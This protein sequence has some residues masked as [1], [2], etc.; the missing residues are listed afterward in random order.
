MQMWIDQSVTS[1]SLLANLRE[2]AHREVAWEQFV[3]RYGGRIYEWCLLKR[4]QPADAEDVTQNVL[5][6]LVRRLCDFEYHSQ[7]SF[8]GWLRRVTE[9]AIIDF[10]REQR[11]RNADRLNPRLCELLELSEDRE[12]LASRLERA[13]DIELF[14]LARERVRARVDSRRWMAWE[15]TSIDQR[16]SQEVALELDMKVPTVYSSRYQVQ[17]LIT[18]EI[19]VLESE[20][21]HFK[22]QT[23]A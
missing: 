5:I 21:G 8:R 4:L 13:F 20:S 19:R 10:H 6:K 14:D 11:V 3:R 22:E 7:L 12:D 1:V 9:N 23:Q 17:K 16:S 18:E 2:E 15:M